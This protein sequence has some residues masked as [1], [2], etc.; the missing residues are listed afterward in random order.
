INAEDPRTFVPSPG[1]VEELY[2]PGGYGIRVDTHLYCGYVV[3]PFYDSL[4]AK[5]IAWGR[6]REEAIARALRALEEFKVSGSGLKTN[7]EFHKLVL[8]SR[9]FQ[10]GRQHIRFVE[11]LLL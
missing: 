8:S 3:P 2:L 10:Q 1:K 11:E 4:L 5:L 7:I 6:T 9:E